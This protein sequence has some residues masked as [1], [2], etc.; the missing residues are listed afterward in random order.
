MTEMELVVPKA[1][2]RV[3]IS[4]TIQLYAQLCWTN[5]GRRAADA[6]ISR[7]KIG[8]GHGLGLGR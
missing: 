6:V 1:L 8:N 7:G 2:E 5:I 3:L 4:S